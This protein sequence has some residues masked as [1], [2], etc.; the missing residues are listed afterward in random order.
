MFGSA[1]EGGEVA[2][3]EIFACEAG[4]YGA[5]AIVN[6]DGGVVECFCHGCGGEVVVRWRVW[7]DAVDSQAIWCISVSC[8]KEFHMDWK[9]D[10]R[11]FGSWRSVL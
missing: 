2:F 7:M 3:W 5:A 4:S 8:V 6:H 10:R 9:A 11:S 1:N